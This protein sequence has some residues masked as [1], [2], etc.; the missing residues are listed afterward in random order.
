GPQ[1]RL[2]VRLEYSFQSSDCTL[3]AIC[4]L[5]A[6]LLL[7]RYKP[8][9][10]RHLKSAFNILMGLA[11]HPRADLTAFANHSDKPSNRLDRLPTTITDESSASARPYA[12]APKTAKA[13]ALSG[14]G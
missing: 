5:N 10:S 7:R 1:G 14:R 4:T 13:L 3:H 12:S 9:N 11:I 2:E 8:I 6:L